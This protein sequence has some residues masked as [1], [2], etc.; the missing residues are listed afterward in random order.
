[1]QRVHG[2]ECPFPRIVLLLLLLLLLLFIS[3]NFYDSNPTVMDYLF[4]YRFIYGIQ[5]A[6]KW[7]LL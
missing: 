6:A 3:W 2:S 4:L 1:M 7:Q 5:V